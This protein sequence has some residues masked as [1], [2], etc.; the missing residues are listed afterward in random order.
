MIPNGTGTTLTIVLAVTGCACSTDP[1]ELEDRDSHSTPDAVADTM[2]VDETGAH[3]TSTISGCPIDD[4]PLW[5]SFATLH[6][7][8][9][10]PQQVAL[11]WRHNEGGPFY[12]TDWVA[13]EDIQGF[14]VFLGNECEPR[15]RSGADVSQITLANL[16]PDTSYV[17]R[18]EA[19][20]GHGRWSSNGPSTRVRTECATYWDDYCPVQWPS[21]A[22]ISAVQDGP[23]AVV[24]SWTAATD[25]LGIVFYRLYQDDIV[26]DPVSGIPASEYTTERN[27]TSHRVEALTGGH[28]Y[29]FSVWARDEKGPGTPHWQTGP[30]VRFT[31]TAPR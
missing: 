14:G 8:N 12:P 22:T 27:V 17:F 2:G 18:I 13:T 24:L 31:L 23:D 7:G 10:G 3:S 29:L 21:G 4:G 9:V 30:S 25:N 19:V 28:E 11:E 1:I 16:V 20:D 15:A 5:S 6:A 26:V